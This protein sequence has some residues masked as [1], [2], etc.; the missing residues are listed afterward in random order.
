M[1]SLSSPRS[2]ALAAALATAVALLVAPAAAQT[3]I[4]L[5]NLTTTTE[6][7]KLTIKHVDF[8]G[9]NITAEEATKL[10]TNATR[11]EA[12]AIL[13]KL[14]AKQIVIPEA[15]VGPSDNSGAIKLHNLTATDV[16]KG[17]VAR[18]SLDSFDG[19]GRD[20]TGGPVTLKGGSV[21]IDKLEAGQLLAA[22]NRGG[23]LEGLLKASRV[24]FN[25][26]DITAPDKDTPSDA[27]GGNLV[28]MKLSSFSAEQTYE[29][30]TPA[31][32][33][34]SANGFSL[35]MPKASKAGASLAAEGYE[36]VEAN[37]RFAGAYDPAQRAY[38]LDEL[39]VESPGVA[40]L[41][42]RGRFSDFASVALTG[43]AEARA[44][45]LAAS[46]IDALEL[47]LVNAGAFEKIVTHAA[48][49]K[50]KTPTQLLA[51]WKAASGALLP[52]LAGGDLV[53]AAAADAIGKF[54][55]NP[56][57]L[58]VAVKGKAGPVKVVELLAGPKPA[59]LLAKVDF[60]FFTEGR[61]AAAPAAKTVAPGVAQ[62]PQPS[63][64]AAKLTGL[65]AWSALIGNTVAGK[66]SDGE[67]LFEFYKP[68]GTLKQLNGDTVTGGK[69]VMRGQKVCI[70][71]SGDDEETC[72]QVEV[73]GDVATFTDDGGDGQ[74]YKIMPGNAK[75]L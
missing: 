50:N 18:L 59:D 34:L 12:A 58:T 14:E 67:P 52:A 5:D 47:R 73:F 2:R 21:A 22:L 39:S 69:W 11:E 6:K 36:R 35:Q 55:D 72:Y 45:A 29:G 20:K 7:S 26:I 46:S 62:A 3:N 27:P 15:T 1:S 17:V 33:I 70:V 61:Q 19:D 44:A 37:M 66:D 43:K 10:L 56:K 28:R 24:T 63:T 65:Q 25:A 8:I 64:A 75:G 40:S 49:D 54:L 23:P 53:G 42:L 68:D 32:T 51:E 60:A 38:S 16:R 57:S 41:R 48:K 4:A 30:E 31:R 9:T 13:A 74:R 71:Y